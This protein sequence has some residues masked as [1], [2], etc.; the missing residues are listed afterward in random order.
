MVEATF[1][2][3]YD[4]SEHPWSYG[5][6]LRYDLFE[7]DPSFLQVIISSRGR[8]SVQSGNDAPYNQVAAGVV[9]NLKLR[10]GQQNQIMVVALEEEG[11]L[12]VNQTFIASFD[13]SD[14]TVS[15][16]VAIMTGAYA[17]SEKAGASTKYEN[18][19]GY[20]L[21][22]RYGPTRRN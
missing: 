4:A 10:G 5:F 2:N 12:F 16:D 1:T 21:S 3:P 18:F 15:G 7:D 20:D 6:F 8:W 11:W 14:V 19:R 13:L 9:S 22:R 17:G